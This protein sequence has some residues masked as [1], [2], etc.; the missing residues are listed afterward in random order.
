MRSGSVFGR[1]FSSEITIGLISH[2]IFRIQAA[3]QKLGL[4]CLPGIRL[5]VMAWKSSL[6]SIVGLV[7]DR[8]AMG[9]A[10]SKV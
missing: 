1:I 7:A 8:Q 2:P 10:P 5:L 6:Y 3:S 4:L 9:A